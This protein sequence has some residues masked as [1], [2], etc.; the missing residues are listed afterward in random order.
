MLSNY[1]LLVNDVHVDNL[2]TNHSFNF[3]KVAKHTFASR[4]EIHDSS[5][6]NISGNV[7]ELDR[8]IDDLGIYNGEYI[9]IT[10]STF[11][12]IDKTLANIYRGGTDESTFG[13]H[14]LF[15]NNELNNIGNG[16]RNKVRASVFLLGVQVATLEN[17]SVTRS[18]PIRI[19]ETVGDPITRLE[20]N[21]FTETSEPVIGPI[22]DH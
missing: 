13:P 1:E 17:N 15:A 5:F 16:K 6:A 21:Q 12:N 19:V 7:L 10:D 20:N 14:F 11:E 22:G 8:E 2:N 4:I 3:L 18:Q 9:T